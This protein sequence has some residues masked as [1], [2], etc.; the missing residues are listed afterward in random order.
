MHLRLLVLAAALLPLP[1]RAQDP[2]DAVSE[3]FEEVNSVA[4]Y[5]HAATLASDGE[6]EGV[7]SGVGLEVFLNLPSVGK[8]EFELGLGANT[9]S[10]FEAVEPSLDLRGQI[11]TLP[12][13]AIYGVLDST[14]VVEP[15][16]GLQF[17]VAELWNTRGYA[18][19]GTIYEAGSETFELGVV[20]GGYLDAGPL[21]GLYA[22]V[23][24]RRRRFESVTWGEAETLPEGWPRAIDASTWSV[25]L[26]WQFRIRDK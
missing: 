20:G 23:A 18:E 6:L 5:T 12:T 25:T 7:L 19:D 24:F 26:G 10:G 11:R 21:R 1:A 15:Y 9:L 4:F 17:G 16:L 22:E 13:L 3:L 8:A 2:M 14:A